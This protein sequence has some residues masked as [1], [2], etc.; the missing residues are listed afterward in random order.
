MVEAA[1]R[2]HGA[3]ELVLPR[4]AK[5]RMAKVVGQGDRLGEVRLESKC[6]RDGTGDLGHL[7]GMGQ[8]RPVVV[9]L[10]GHEDLG[11]LLEPPE[12]GGVDDP[13][14][15]PGEGRAGPA[16]R[17]DMP[18]TAGG[19]G[20]LGVGGAGD[21]HSDTGSLAAAPSKAAEPGSYRGV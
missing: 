6:G 16:L 17:F 15:V 11:L 2:L 20:A 9:A 21:R 13:V 19:G 14:T 12:G 18:A 8:P 4:M 5:G 10:V 1:K 3:V 7:K